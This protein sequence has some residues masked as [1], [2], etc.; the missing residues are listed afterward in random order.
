MGLTLAQ[1]YRRRRFVVFGGAA[2][3]LAGLTYLPLTLLAPVEPT[4][5]SLVS[6]ETPVEELPVLDWPGS[7]SA[8]VGAVGFP[9]VLESTGSSEPRAIASIT[10]II[11]ALVVLDEHPLEAGEPGPDI[12]FDE[13][14]VRFHK[15]YLAVNGS[16]Q[17]VSAGLTLSQR[18][19]LTVVL[20]PSANNYAKSLAIWAFGSEAKFLAAADA[21][22]AAQGMDQTR[23]HEPTGMNPHNVSTPADLL[24]LAKL[25]L[26]DPTVSQIV[27][28]A[29]VTIPGVGTFDNSNKLLGQLGI[30]GIKTGTL[31]EAGACLLFSADF[32]VGSEL[33]TVVGVALGGVDHKS[34]FPQVRT[35]LES[36]V[37]GFHEVSLVSEGDV[38]ARYNTP[39]NTSAKAVASRAY[40]E[41]VWG[42][43]PIAMRVD[44]DVLSTAEDGDPVG[45]VTF[46]L[47]ERKIRV[48]LELDGTLEGPDVIWRLTNPFTTA[49]E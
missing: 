22:L 29:T 45:T 31:D 16:V 11:T 12:R 42:K 27:A 10:K 17:P 43:E 18:E 7:V 48:P 3:T 23:I 37:P 26:A 32:T 4:S 34:Q 41:L 1:R 20:V 36:V 47:D 14:D 21:W 6:F 40:T 5:P 15:E 30:D 8:A 13:A 49:F 35:L 38:L 28:M 46:T 2:I 44:A 39:W 33:V 24:E 19:L 9:G 25:A